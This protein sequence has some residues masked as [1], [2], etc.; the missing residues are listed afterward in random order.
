MT[1]LRRSWPLFTSAGYIACYAPLSPLHMHFYPSQGDATS[2]IYLA[3]ALKAGGLFSLSDAAR[4]YGYI[5]FLY[6]CSLLFGSG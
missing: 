2:Y 1:E 3:Q 6:F 4:T 5:W